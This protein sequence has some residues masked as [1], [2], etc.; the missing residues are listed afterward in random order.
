MAADDLICMVSLGEKAIFMK[1]CSTTRFYE[2]KF[3]VAE[4]M[5]VPEEA[6]SLVYK[7]ERH[8][9]LTF[10]VDNEDDLKCMLEYN[11]NVGCTEIHMLA[12]VNSAVNKECSSSEINQKVI[13][14]I[15]DASLNEE[16]CHPP[17]GGN[18]SNSERIPNDCPSGEIVMRADDII[19][20]TYSIPDCWHTTLT[21]KGQQFKTVN[22]LRLALQYYSMAKKFDYD[23]VKNEPKRIRVICR[24][25]ETYG[26][27]WMLFV[28]PIKN[29]KRIEIK[30]FVNEHSYGQH[31]NLSG[32]SR[33][34]RRFVAE[35]LRPVLKVRPE[36]R[37]KDVQKE[38]LTRYG[39]RLEYS[40]IWWGKE[41]AQ[42]AM[43]GDSYESYD[44]LRCSYMLIYITLMFQCITFTCNVVT[45]LYT[46]EK[47]VKETN[48][49][50][51]IC[52]DQNE[53]RFKRLF[54]CYA[55]CIVG[56]LNGCR[57]LLFLDGTFLKDRYKG[58][59]LSAV[60]YDG[61]QGIFPL[62]Y[63]ICDQENVDNWRWF[64][65]GLWSILYER[66]DPYNPPHQL[67][68]I[69]DADKGIQEANDYMKDIYEMSPAA[70]EIV[71]NYSP[72]H[73]ANAFFPGIR[74]GHVTSNVAESFNSWIREA[75]MLRILQM[76]EHI[77]KQ[78][79]TRMNNRRIMA[80]KWTS[81][82]C[83]KAEQIVGEH[84]ERGSTLEIKQ[85]RD[86]IFEVQSQRT[87]HVDLGK[88]TCTCRA[89]DLTRIPCVYACAVIIYMK[90]EVYQYYDWFMSVEAF[91][92]SYDEILYPIPDYEMR[93]VPKDEIQILPP[94]TMKWR[95]RNR[96]R[97]IN[98]ITIMKRPVKCGRCKR[99]GHN[100]ATCNEPIHD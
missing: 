61:D 67:V 78:I 17:S 25:K 7:S 52:I 18:A 48:P 74:Y 43:Y 38:F 20:K 14:G 85:S 49:G 29:K 55:A 62:A 28:S 92:K 26:C 68:I 54:I 89:W 63:C 23:F 47:K 40:K 94:I 58:L 69:S 11:R 41:R 70:Y 34:S 71:I 99:E 77:R 19:S 6:L 72:E 36:I 79:M 16:Y 51:Y 66:P 84:M 30:R 97:R 80:E 98:N 10:S 88:R 44:Q 75:R 46:Y 13:G 95:G 37:P 4:R 22:D 76:V 96:T 65:Q 45:L 93:S 57:P 100:R 53:G 86:D 73:W 21:K 60:A 31:T 33:A 87:T 32:Q 90:R 3:D 24:Y 1:L 42:E 83:P 56:F 91:K 15:S 50:S 2:L 12:V 9:N 8:P 81:Y 64:L 5:K 59:L 35:Q 39:L 82:L 27:P